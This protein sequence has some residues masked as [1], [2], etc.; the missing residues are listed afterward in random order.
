MTP[1]ADPVDSGPVLAWW[2]GLTPEAQAAAVLV[3]PEVVGATNGIPAWARDRANRI[4]LARAE[5]D[6][7]G[8]VDSAAQCGTTTV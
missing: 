1:V 7:A 5:D 8:A 3:R 6:L 4:L 2:R